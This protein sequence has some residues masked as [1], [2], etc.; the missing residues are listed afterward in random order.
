M[1]STLTPTPDTPR[2]DL[3]ACLPSLRTEL[4]RQRRFRLDQLAALGG[5]V[6]RPGGHDLDLLHAGQGG[7][8]SPEIVEILSAAALQSL[9][10]IDIALRR[11]TTGRYGSCLDCG[12]EIPLERL[13]AVP[14]TLLCLGCHLSQNLER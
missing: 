7:G 8:A 13:R 6:D 5:R 2:L 10:D 1:A 12:M 9:S 4:E 3:V 11:M 14:Q